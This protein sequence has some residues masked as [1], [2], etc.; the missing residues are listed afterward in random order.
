M[1]A[2]G[3]RAL[4]VQFQSAKAARDPLTYPGVHRILIRLER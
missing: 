3:A 2:I 4:H 1:P